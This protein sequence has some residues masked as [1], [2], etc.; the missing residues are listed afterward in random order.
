M[1]GATSGNIIV[2]SAQGLLRVQANTRDGFV[3]VLCFYSPHFTSTLLSE[4]DVYV[5][6]NIPRNSLPM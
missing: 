3:D 2:P 4:R 1:R 6:V 5:L